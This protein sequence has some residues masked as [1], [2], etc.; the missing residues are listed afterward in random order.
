MKIQ[1]I[2]QRSPKIEW[3]KIRSNNT[4]PPLYRSPVPGGWL[5]G[6]AEAGIAN[7]CFVPDPEHL[8]D[9]NSLPREEGR[10]DE[11]DDDDDDSF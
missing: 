3:Q 7:I 9:G 5:I 6:S 10:H 8:W 1:N 2:F 11:D 4:M